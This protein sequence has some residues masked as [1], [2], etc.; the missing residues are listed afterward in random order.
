MVVFCRGS[1]ALVFCIKAI[2]SA[3]ME[4]CMYVYYSWA[5]M[6][7]FIGGFGTFAILLQLPSMRLLHTKLI[8]H[9]N[10]CISLFT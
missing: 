9:L 7:N 2:P 5:Y 6:Q 3:Y 1:G 10:L 4:F 8:S